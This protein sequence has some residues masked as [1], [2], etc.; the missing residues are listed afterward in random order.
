M[1]VR[2]FDN[3]IKWHIIVAMYVRK[4][5]KRQRGQDLHPLPP[6]GVGEDPQGAEAEDGVRFGGSATTAPVGVAQAGAQGGG[7]AGVAGGSVSGS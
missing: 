1:V 6:S 2:F 3:L 7:G 5:T 4:T